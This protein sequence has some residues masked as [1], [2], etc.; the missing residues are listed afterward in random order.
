MES[1]GND[2]GRDVSQNVERLTS[3]SSNEIKDR[4]IFRARRNVTIAGGERNESLV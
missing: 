4:V 3:N 1:E 2:E